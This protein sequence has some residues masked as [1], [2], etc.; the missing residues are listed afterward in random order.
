VSTAVVSVPS[1]NNLLVKL[2]YLCSPFLFDCSV[3]IFTQLF[4][5]V[6]ER[7]DIQVF[8]LYIPPDDT[9]VSNV[10]FIIAAAA[11][12]AAAAAQCINSMT[13]VWC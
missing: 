4:S 13:M 8:S 11:A 5:A 6:I 10:A 1:L 3:A 7:G 12:A 9:T 2:C